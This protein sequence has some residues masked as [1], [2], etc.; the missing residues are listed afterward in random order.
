[1]VDHQ[2]GKM[3]LLLKVD[4]HL[5]KANR[6][7]DILNENNSPINNYSTIDERCVEIYIKIFETPYFLNK[8]IYISFLKQN[9]IHYLYCQGVKSHHLI[10]KIQ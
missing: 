2:L 3:F 1:M 7:R 10:T 4:Y 8:K 5:K 9:I 6:F